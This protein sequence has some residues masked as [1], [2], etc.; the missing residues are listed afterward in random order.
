MSRMVLYQ[1]EV[2]YPI[3]NAIMVDMV[4]HLLLCK[5][6]A[7]A[8]LHDNP[9]FKLGDPVHIDKPIPGMVQVSGRRRRVI[10]DTCASVR[11]ELLAATPYLELNLT[12]FAKMFHANILTENWHYNEHGG[13]I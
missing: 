5:L 1:L 7:K 12:A 13:T 9:V 11:T 8:L 3:V 10:K 4:D 2:L 6:S